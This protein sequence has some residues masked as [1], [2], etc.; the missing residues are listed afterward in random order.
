[1]KFKGQRNIIFLCLF[2]LPTIIMSQTVISS[3]N[4]NS[5]WGNWN[6]GGSNATLDYVSWIFPTQAAV[7]HSQDDPNST[8][9]SDVTNLSAYGSVTINFD[10]YFRAVPSAYSLVIDYSND[11]GSSWSEVERFSASS[12]NNWNI[13]SVSSNISINDFTLTNNSRFRFRS[14]TNDNT[15]IIYVDNVT[16]TGYAP[17]EEIMISSNSFEITDGDTTPYILDNTDY[18]SADLGTTMTRSFTISN[19]G[20]SNLSIGAITLSN[21]TDFSIVTSP[22]ATITNGS[23]SILSIRY[24]SNI[25]GTASTTVSV[26]NS[27]AD[28]DPYDFTIQANSSTNFFD[29][30]GDGV[31]D[32][33][34]IDDDN[35]G[36]EDSLEELACQNSS[37]A[38]TSD[39]KF[40]NETF[41]TGTRAQIN[42]TYDAITTYC[43]EDGTGTCDSTIN[44][45]DGAYTVYYQATDG[46]GDNTDVPIDDVANWAEQ[47]WF[48]GGDHTAGDTNGRMALFNAAF[49]PGIFYTASIT[50]ALPN[51]PV[52]YSFWVLNLDTV[53]AP[54]IASRLRPDI[55]VEFRDVDDNVLA[56]ITTGDIPPSNNLDPT[57]SWYNFSADLTF[58]V[59]EFN[60]YFYNNQLGGLGNDL[61]LD[62]IEIRQTL[63][64]TDY[65]GVADVFDLDSDNDGI[66][67]VVEAGHGTYSN[68]TATIDTSDPNWDL[69]GNGMDDT[70]EG[71]MPLD[72]DGDGTPNF[73]DL[74]SDNDSIFDVDE[75]GAGNIA[76][77]AFQNGDG[78]IDGNGTGDGLDTDEVRE[79]DF[80]SD[81]TSEYYTDGILDI[82]D[83][84]SG[85]T[86]GTAYGNSNQG[87]GHTYYVLDSDGDGDPD[88]MDEY[89][90]LTGTF[91]IS[92]TL[93]AH[94]D[95]AHPIDG[96]IDDVNDSD[97]DGILD[98][99]D[100][101]DATFGSPRDL[102]QKLQLYFDGRN[103]YVEDSQILSGLGAAT[104]MGWVKI[105]ASFSGRAIL[106]GQDNIELEFQDYGTPT[107]IARVNGTTLSNDNST[108]P[109][110]KGRWTHVALVFDGSSEMSLYLNG[111]IIETT[112]SIGAILNTNSYG[113]TIGKASDPTDTSSYFSGFLDE[114]RVFNSALSQD[115]VQKLV[116]QEIEDN[117]NVRG[118]EIPKDVNTLP[119]GNVLRYFRLDNFKG[120]ITD[121]LTT[122]TVDTGS[123]AKLYNIKTIEYQNAP[124]PF[125][126]QTGN[127]SLINAVD[128][129]ADGVHGQD[130]ATYD[131]SI[132]RVEHD[133]ITY[134][135]TQRHLGLFVNE[136]DASTDP[137]TYTVDNGSELTVSWYL[138]LDGKIDLE[139]DSQLVQTQDSDLVVGTNGLLE[140]D[141]QGTSNIYHY[142]YW[143][144]PIGMTSTS[145]SDPDN[146]NRYSY[147]VQDILFDGNSAVNFTSSSYDGAP[148]TPITIADY[149]IWKFAD[150]PSGNY[151]EWEHVRSTGN[152]LPGEGYTMKGSGASSPLQSYTFRGKPNNKIIELDI[153]ANNDYLI[154]NPYASA[155]DAD[156]FI[157]DNGPTVDFNQPTVTEDDQSLS[158][159]LY[160]WEHWGGS[161]HVLSEYQGG[162]ATYNY[163]GGVAAPFSLTGDSDPDVSPIGSGTKTP[164]RYIP[165]G[166]GFFVSADND[167][168]INFNN[169]QRVFRLENPTNGEFIRSANEI[170][171]DEIDDRMKLK[172]GFNSVTGIHRQI[173]LTIDDRTTQGIDWAFDGDAFGFQPDDMLWL[174]ENRFL[175]IQGANTIENDVIYPLVVFTS[176]DGDNT[177]TIDELTNYDAEQAIY[178]HDSELNLYHNL[179]DSDYTVFL[180]S[181]YY[182]SRFK[183]VFNEINSLSNENY[184][185]N[186]YYLDIR[187]SNNS[188]KI[189]VTNPS[190]IAIDSISIYSLLGQRIGVID[191]IISGTQT[192]YEFNNTS[193]GTY[194]LKLD[195]ENGTL[196]RKVIIN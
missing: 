47:Y 98:L 3:D 28:E 106:F 22:S 128:I 143:S 122:P 112:N 164:G 20:T 118:T 178:M 148:T 72:S 104:I 188:E 14:D 10:F 139:G 136:T 111:E 107:L 120:D 90:D 91:D 101:D 1:M 62:D 140:K 55:R 135:N 63:C 146:V 66:P 81:G 108:D 183:I 161:S 42:T 137:I 169:G 68:G 166:Q 133:G 171:E 60:V 38:I 193:P 167:G 46:D 70:L 119:W 190:N 151:S 34:D 18:G 32:N 94:L 154:G 158:G 80:N 7:I 45:N 73:L 149:W 99:F 97:Q 109:I 61:A 185:G 117:G 65:D 147:A 59:S 50:G 124:M 192:Q 141:Q 153:D 33:I 182:D 123:G 131:W 11:G 6:D 51:V 71:S 58:N 17:E 83:H 175:A 116:Y 25:V 132:V 74:D 56:T 79:K 145:P 150:N 44:L 102:D 92:T 110:T 86:M 82:Y 93:Y 39:Y 163:S 87:M 114:I 21:T 189:I 187:Y 19:T 35:D 177:F 186:Q 129:V 64:D 4:F 179:R 113:F 75:S 181:G 126:T 12:Y 138:Q 170:A 8:F 52:T 15:D 155:L 57:N 184:P 30:D 165:V 125:V 180:N 142:N 5:G 159:T 194:I 49:D 96:I 172:L 160:F 41:G 156:Q 85:A 152:I 168:T 130:A 103:D 24:E 127:T 95:V 27:D 162:Y 36:I 23:S 31:F 88:Y 195:T 196:T 144:S 89:N 69:N 26:V 37:I 191:D 84:F 100:T 13:H 105:N 54:G 16:V 76:N 174:V 173:L 77:P 67:D 134:N 115:E 9:Y 29:S 48:T 53:T 78:D 121:D 40:L 176:E 43:Y 157:A 2:L